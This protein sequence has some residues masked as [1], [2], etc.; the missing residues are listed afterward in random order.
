MVIFL[1][2]I[3]FLVGGWALGFLSVSVNVMVMSSKGPFRPSVSDSGI[4]IVR[5]STKQNI[6]VELRMNDFML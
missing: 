4:T 1:H 5:N 3:L 2:S 6:M